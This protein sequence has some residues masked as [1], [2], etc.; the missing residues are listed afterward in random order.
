LT[1]T[2]VLVNVSPEVDYP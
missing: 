1:L 2:V